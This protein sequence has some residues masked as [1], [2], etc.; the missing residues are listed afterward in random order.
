MNLKIKIRVEIEN[1]W[2]ELTDTQDVDIEE[3]DI[4]GVA[5]EAIEA[6]SFRMKAALSPCF[7]DHTVSQYKTK[8]E[9]EHE[10]QGEE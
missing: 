7:W 4:E 1:T 5:S 6:L 9:T 10:S 8:I 2:Y 3:W